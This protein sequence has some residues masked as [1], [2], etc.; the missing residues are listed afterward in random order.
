MEGGHAGPMELPGLSRIYF[1]N[2]VAPMVLAGMTFYPISEAA[3]R[4]A[5]ADDAAD[6][7][8]CFTPPCRA[9]AFFHHTRTL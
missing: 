3:R 7:R 2:H 4:S 6:R 9:A 8:V 1:Y 5:L